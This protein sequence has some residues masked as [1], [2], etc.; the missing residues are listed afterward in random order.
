MK[1]VTIKLYKYREL[2]AE[3][4]AKARDIRR[5][6][7]SGFNFD[8][9]LGRVQ[10]ALEAHGFNLKVKPVRQKGNPVRALYSGTWSAD[11]CKG[12]E[13]VPED[14]KDSPLLQ[15]LSRSLTALARFCI[16]SNTYSRTVTFNEA[17]VVTRH[18]LGDSV[19]E[20]RTWAVL[21]PLTLK[22][23][24]WLSIQLTDYR[25][26]LIS[27]RNIEEMLEWEEESNH[28]F[29]KDGQVWPFGN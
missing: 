26:E 19:K 9:L 20:L 22:L 25:D 17:D 5:A 11:L 15:D 16:E 14:F 27:D 6:A 3:A 4:Q 7:I 1:K 13:Q 2:D 8:P 24:E 21:K 12:M 29:M 28:L 10:E 18:L 23:G